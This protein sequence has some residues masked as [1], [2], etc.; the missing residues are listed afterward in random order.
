MWEL[1][2]TENLI[3]LISSSDVKIQLP[4][5]FVLIISSI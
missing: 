1:K 4:L 2:T 5:N 3:L